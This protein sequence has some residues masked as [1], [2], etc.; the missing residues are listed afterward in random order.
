MDPRACAL[1]VDDDP[2]VLTL[3]QEALTTSAVEVVPAS[4]A[5]DALARISDQEFDLLIADIG[6]PGMDGVSL[7]RAAI[8]A[9]PRL[10]PIA[11]SGYGT[12]PIAVEAVKAGALD[13]LEKPLSIGRLLALVDRAIE[14]H[15]L[16][17][18]TVELRQA[19]AV[20]ELSQALVHELDPRQ[21]LTKVVECAAREYAADEATI[22]V[23][24]EDG[25]L[26][27]AATWGP[28]RER[29][30]GEQV[31]MDGGPVSWV[32]R[33]RKPLLLGGPPFAPGHRPVLPRADVQSSMICPLLAGDHLMGVLTVAG[34]RQGHRFTRGQ[35]KTLSIFAGIAAASL[36]VA[37]EHERAQA[38]ERGRMRALEE[39]RDALIR[40]V[41]A[42]ASAAEQR[43]AYTAGHE[44]R[45]AELASAIA[46][47]LGLPE[48]T[49]EGIRLGGL[50]HDIGKIGI[51]TE[52]L[53]CPR[54]LSR[55][56]MSLIRTH[57]QAG[58]EILKDVAF[59]WP[60]AEMARQHHERLDGSGYPRRLKGPEILLEAKVIAVADV[61]EAMCSHRP[62]RPAR[63]VESALQVIRR[64]AGTKFDRPTVDAC[65][66]VVE[67]Q[68]FGRHERA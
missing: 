7:I 34:T 37:T 20:Y 39:L 22:L 48:E 55:I 24:A 35:L 13:F 9:D 53:V 4:T 52:L 41:A 16:R 42:M 51:P 31:V 26:R 5:E 47:E 29:L 12:I 62:Y 66:R 17:E 58:Y 30:L 64:G 54:P 44:R 38:A 10:V 27:I 19:V 14:V 23:S 45:V 33:E 63:G 28:G 46:A 56:E 43:D 1:V 60:V 8:A 18:D 65:L 21:V 36:Q 67:E 6:L 61:V 49:V 32:I 2:A 11:I 50:V 68:G 57:A 3:L 59:P 25:E 40:T 15:R